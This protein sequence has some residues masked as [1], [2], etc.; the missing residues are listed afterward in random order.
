MERT[1]LEQLLRVVATNAAVG[2]N[3]ANSFLNGLGVIVPPATAVLNGLVGIVNTEQNAI[4]TNL[5]DDILQGGSREVSTGSDPDV[6]LEVVIDGL[7]GHHAT[8]LISNG[9][10]DI[11]EPVVDTPEVEGNVFALVTNNNLQLGEAVEHSVGD[12]AQGVQADTVGEGQRGSNQ[13]LALGVQLVKNDI[14]RSSGVDVQGDI[15]LGQ[16]LPELVVGGLVV[17]EIGLA[18]GTG[19][20]EVAK[21]STVESELLNTATQLLA[22]LLRVVHRQTGKST[23]AVTVVLDLIGR[24]VVGLSGSLLGQGFVG[25][26]LDTGDG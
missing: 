10:L 24:P 22:S 15:Q 20:L 18:V 6:L 4:G 26:T 8:L 11:F 12:Q 16:D 9:P 25:N 5:V 21:E 14:R 7:L 2:I 23:H 17:V 19:V 13:I 1:Q 3:T